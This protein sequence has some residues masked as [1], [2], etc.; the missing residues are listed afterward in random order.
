MS[1]LPRQ[2]PVPAPSAHSASVF[3]THTIVPTMWPRS[4]TIGRTIQR[5]RAVENER[6]VLQRE[7]ERLLK[8]G[9]VMQQD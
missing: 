3:S 2:F 8:M 5:I 1:S 6:R 7:T 9:R 4:V